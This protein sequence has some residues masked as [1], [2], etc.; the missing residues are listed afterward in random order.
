MRK[1]RFNVADV[2]D[3]Q[4]RLC[5]RPFFLE[6][7][8]EALALRVFRV[9]KRPLGSI[10]L[11]GARKS[12]RGDGRHMDSDRNLLFGVLAL[13]ADLIDADRFAEACSA[14]AAKKATP[15]AELLQERGWI[16]AEERAHVEFL[17]E[18]KL[19]KHGGDAHASLAVA[20]DDRIRGLIAGAN[21]LEVRRSIAE[22]PRGDGPSLTSTLAY[23]PENRERY[24]LTRLHA[25]GGL[26]QVWLAVDGDLN[27]QVAL[28]ELRPERGSDPTLAARFLDE[29]RVTGQLEHPG[30]V[31]VYEL[32]RRSGDG[33]PYYTMR[34][35][36]G[37]T[38]AEAACDYHRKREAGQVGPLDLVALLNAFVGVC[39]AVAYAHSRGVIHR[40]LKPQN[41]V[42]GDFGEVIV[43][44]WGL[45]KLVGRPEEAA[46]FSSVA[47][48]AVEGHAATMP[49]QVLGTP[50]YIPPEQA[51][52][53]AVNQLSDVYGLGAI[54]YE[55]L[56][57]RPPFEGSDTRELLRRVVVE[58]PARP[59]EVMP[60][61]PRAL[62]AVCLKAL[63]K[64]PTDR[65]GSAAELADE[66]RHFLADEPVRAYRERAAA[67]AGRWMRRHRT[68]VSGAA[69]LLV[70]VLAAA[71]VG[72]VLL[73]GKNRE[74][75]AQR[76]AAL[77][78]ANEAEAVNAFL[79]ED[80]LGQADPDAN[81]R[82]KKVTVEELLR[83][84]A[85]KIEGN[86][87]FAGRPEV[88]ATLRLTLGKTFF[89]LS[90]LAEAEKHLRRAVDL[91][92]Q[93][94]GPDDPRTLAAQEALA[95]FLGKGPYRFAEAVPLALHTW[96]GRA[97]V[98][99]PE[100]RDTLD[101]LDTYAGS[102]QDTGRD[103]EANSLHRQCL[104]ARRRTL[105]P[106]HTD[107]LTS[108]NNLAYTLGK[109][110]KFSEAIPLL[111]EA[112][113]A[114]K[115]A[116]PESELTVS[117]A[118]LVNCL[119]SVGQLEEADRLTQ[120]SLERAT[121]RFGPDHQLTDALRWY[122][123]RVWLDQGHVERAVALGRE[124]IVTRRRIY[125]AGHPVIAP[126]LTDLGHGLVLL[127]RFDEAE[128]PL[129]ESVSIFAGSQP[130]FPHYPAWCKCWYG[131]SLAGQ[132]RYAKA[133]PHLLA[134]E[135]GLREARSTPPR[136]YR[137]A[138]E[139]LVKLY[140]AWGKPEEAARWRTELTALSDSQGPSE[141]KGGN[142]SGSGR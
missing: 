129:S 35:I 83:K 13:Q 60:A 124:A 132:H 94:L 48:D 3:G 7:P 120:Q 64:K 142:T 11:C 58:P 76:N 96:Q 59:R 86:P 112:V 2:G 50:S 52:G 41:V 30:I 6:L 46:A 77:T 54:L 102:L 128:A 37:R 14:W 78:A 85:G 107:T 73:G 20:I 12:P 105:G 38:L 29:A 67:R 17:L 138:V 26:G 108:M 80:L 104:A 42:L 22:L 139:Q 62:E 126:A 97:R 34:F 106:S 27:R 133:E 122:Q 98:L 119:Y 40:D 65:Y 1:S 8:V 81:A 25:Q 131:A 91:R 45:A 115:A 49:G 89:Q 70:T 93:T 44:D 109:L 72:L 39:N 87:K 16:T 121:T 137:Q 75:A 118:N 84:A 5:A 9:S 71:A 24:T 28:K 103:E 23:E 32:V 55:I 21:D 53:A 117:C 51:E 47:L 69:I 4:A 140:E 141:G 15:L 125:P 110:G 61:T 113:E 114:R 88:E 116:G 123:V 33:R 101:S 100:H 66:V 130:S 56:T 127:K 95:N 79:T 43:L 36:R 31:P 90:D 92:R 10:R 57:G 135:K 82:D 99:G 19:R 74:I 136:H 134:A 68:L 18:R 63:A 111:R